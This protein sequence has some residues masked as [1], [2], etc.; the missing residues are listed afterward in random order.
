MYHVS[1]LFRND[2][3]ILHYIYAPNPATELILRT[4]SV[5]VVEASSICQR[6]KLE[7]VTH[8]SPRMGKGEVG[9]GGGKCSDGNVARVADLDW[10]IK[11]RKSSH[12]NSASDSKQ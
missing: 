11:S 1:S 12:G 10:V 7:G 2:I 9:P 8:G 4:E 3:V 5:R 6:L